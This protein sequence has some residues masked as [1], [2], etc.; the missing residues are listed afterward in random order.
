MYFRRLRT[1]ADRFLGSDYLATRTRQQLDRLSPPSRP[2]LLR[3]AY[4]DALKWGYW[5]NGN[6]VPQPWSSTA[7]DAETMERAIDRLVIG[8]LP[9]RRLE[10]FG[11]TADLP[12]PQEAPVIR[13]GALDFDPVSDNQDQE[14]LELINLSPTAVDLSGWRVAGAVA[15]TLPAGTVIPSGSS[16]YLSPDKASFLRRDLSPTGGEQR[17]VLGPYSGHLAAEGETI[18]LIDEKGQLHDSHTYSGSKPGFNGDS[19]EDRDRDGFNALMEWALGT[20]DQEFDVLAAP[21]EGRWIYQV[22]AGLTGFV[23]E[24][25]WSEDLQN[26]T[27]LGV[28]ELERVPLENGLE[29]VVVELPSAEVRSFT[30]LRLGR[31]AQ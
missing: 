12:G 20:S 21:T 9:E 27:T 5:E 3:D 24:V 14:Y 29:R 28:V 19:R 22:R 26:W 31:R 7:P 15:M 10:L 4:L 17:F 18:E 30:R 25:E 23:V 2:L 6:I 8:W 16:L 11:N 1:L 13:I